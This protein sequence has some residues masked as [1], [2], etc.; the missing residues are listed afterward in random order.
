LGNQK[1]VTGSR[2]RLLEESISSCSSFLP[3]MRLSLTNKMEK[4]ALN[5]KAWSWNILNV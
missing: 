3:Q 1:L 4:I 5:G 2:R